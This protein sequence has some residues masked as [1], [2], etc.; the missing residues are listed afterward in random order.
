LTSREASVGREELGLDESI[1]LNRI[2][3]NVVVN[4]IIISINSKTKINISI[5]IT[6]KIMPMRNDADASTSSAVSSRARQSR[7]QA[8]PGEA[9]AL[10]RACFAAS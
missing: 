8:E 6:K 9:M 2:D 7:R 1:L 4:M 5:C 10:T 3:L